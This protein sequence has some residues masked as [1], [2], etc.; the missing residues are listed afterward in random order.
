[1][2]RST[3]PADPRGLAPTPGEVAAVALGASSVAAFAWRCQ[4]ELRVTV[5]V[6]AAFELVPEQPMRPA[7]APA[8]VRREV[9]HANNPMRSVRRTTD[10][11]PFLARADVV[12]TG[13]AYAPPGQPTTSL[14]ARVA[15]AHWRPLLDKAVEVVGDLGPGGVRAPFE[16]IP[17]TYERAYGGIGF[18]ANPLGRGVGTGGGA[19]NLVD[20]RD[21]TGVACFAPLAHG[22]PARRH[23]LSA[24][25]EAARRG[26]DAP[27]AEI[28]PELDWSYFQ[29]API[30]QRTDY[31]AGDE[32]VLLQG[33]HPAAPQLRSR[34]PGA[35]GAARVYGLA[36]GDE[37]ASL[38]LVGDTLVIDTDE[39]ACTLVWRGNFTVPSEAALESLVVV[40][41]VQSH[42]VPIEWPAAPPRPARDAAVG[43]APARAASS[44][45]PGEDRFDGTL[46]LD[47]EDAELL[48]P[49]VPFHAGAPGSVPPPIAPPPAP[50]R[51]PVRI[52]TRPEHDFERTL[53]IQ[54][55]PST[56]TALPFRARGSSEP[57][58]PVAPRVVAP[59][60]PVAPVAS[61][62]VPA[63]IAAPVAAPFVPAIAAPMP[64]PAAA[65]PVA[66]P[67]RPRGV[68]EIQ[69][70][71]TAPLAVAV[72]PWG[73]EPSRDAVS[74]VAKATCDLV[75]GEPAK[76]RPEPAPIGGEVFADGERGRVLVHPTDRAPWKPR[77]DVVLVGRAH[78]TGGLATALD[79]ALRFGHEGRGF[80]RRVKVHGDRVWLADG[81]LDA[82]SPAEPFLRM[83]LTWE[84]AF[85]GPRFEPNAA[86]VGDAERLSRGKPVPL[87]NLEDPE[88]P[89]RL[90]S[91]RPPPA[92]FAPVPLAWK[93]RWAALGRDARPWPMLAEAFDWT[94]WQAAPAA[95][96]LPH[97]RGDEPYA[98][99]GVHPRAPVLEGTLPGRRARCFVA[100]EARE[101]ARD[102]RVEEVP[103]ALDT[104][105]FDADAATVTLVWRGV[106][107][108]ADERAPGF[109]AVLT[110]LEG[111]NDPEGATLD[112]AR[113]AL[114][115]R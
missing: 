51:A 71:G 91:Q 47:P 32:W 37:G 98:L 94:R 84:R 22:W 59:V 5:V 92:C 18:Q 72:V 24:L 4:G 10:L 33:L 42:G 88:R 107:P 43:P 110:L 106:V 96:Q 73:L 52:S 48:A 86:G 93:D 14:V 68:D 78:A 89:I 1:M 55:E 64:V 35:R 74:I 109:R 19:P 99:E 114:R 11:A 6:K 8:I 16:R 2:S 12:V 82:P 31:L 54:D 46:A 20:P 103:M 76:M 21:G 3:P 60:A 85:G 38:A 45:P 104:I 80:E 79:V 17:L 97:L 36:P 75:P 15:V 58:L 105:V 112:D 77:A 108:V 30:D 26:L 44:P 57:L 61:P 100:F 9:H 53:D 65:P 95:Q 41:G 27:I 115:P 66:A 63:P 34:L 90:A 23:M 70:V 69:L 7:P 87:P 39:Q 102:E 101:G 40:G 56:A 67:A 28:P 50:P 83:P 113:A 13:H 25:P 62:F 81:R 29:V 49:S 111:A